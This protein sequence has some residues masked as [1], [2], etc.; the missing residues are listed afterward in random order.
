MATAADVQARSVRPLLAAARSKRCD[1]KPAEADVQ[2]PRKRPRRDAAIRAHQAWTLDHSKS[3]LVFDPL[4]EG[5][6]EAAIIWLHGLDDTPEPWA[7]R[8]DAE[9]RRRP[10]WKWVHLRAPER[11]ITCYERKLHSAWGD[12]TDAGAVCVGSR[13]HE[14]SDPKGWFA[15][16][17]ALVHAARWAYP[18]R[19]PQLARRRRV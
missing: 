19:T 13:D 2:A 5:P 16:S 12:F 1:G 8:L 18:S 11:A 14:S 7:S 4:E 15:E 10:R 3:A 9:R 6:C 17:V